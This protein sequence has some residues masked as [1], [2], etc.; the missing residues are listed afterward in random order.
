MGYFLDERRNWALNLEELQ[1]SL[2][3]A[4][5]EGKLVR[6]LVFIN[7]GN[8]TGKQGRWYH[9]K[10]SRMWLWPSERCKRA[11]SVH[12]YGVWDFALFAK[13]WWSGAL[14]AHAHSVAVHSVAVQC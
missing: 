1:R 11:R 3:E 10:D 6:G 2:K 12:C 5:D 14:D 7:P 13:A 4:R 9:G 8:P